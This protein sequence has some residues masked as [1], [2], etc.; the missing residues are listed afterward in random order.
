MLSE[1]EKLRDEGCDE[2]IFITISSKMSGIYENAILAAKMVEGIK[3]TV[4]DSRSVGYVEC[5]MAFTAHDMA[6]EGKS[7][8]EIVKTL[9]FIRDNN[10]IYFA[11]EDLKYLVKNGRLSN[12]AG[13]MADVLK[14]KP[15]LE[16]DKTGAVVTVEKIRTFP[17]ALKRVLEKFL[18]ETEG[19]EYEPFIIHANN[20]EAVA[21]LRENVMALRPEVKEITR[22]IP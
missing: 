2:A 16:I 9:E 17:K 13:F 15:L 1:Y 22:I 14:I 8:D 20:P 7:M 18:E 21:F 5:K 10:H 19:K 4:F 12:A 11:V 6:R 3:V